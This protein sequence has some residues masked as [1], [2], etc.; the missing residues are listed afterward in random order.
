MG[1]EGAIVAFMATAATVFPPDANPPEV[2]AAFEAAPPEMVAEIIDGEL[3]LVPRPRLR[4]GRAA[5]RLGRLLGD[6]DDEGG[7]W[8]ILME[9]ELHLGSKPDKL[10]PDVAGWRRE[11]LPEIPDAAAITIAPD[12]VCEVLSDRTR[13]IDR[14][15]KQRIYAREG[16]KHLWFVEPEAQ[17]VEVL[18]LSGR[19]WLVV[20]TFEADAVVRMEP[21]EAAELPLSAL[22]AR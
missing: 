7:G 8:V 5:S 2:E 6:F 20:D 15:K 4:H 10:V 19:N 18:R 12:W 16:V 3:S 9:P 22:W 1:L 11:R 14:G 13:R 21:F 17:L